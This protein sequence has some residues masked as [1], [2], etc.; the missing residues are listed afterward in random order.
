[1][2]DVLTN[3]FQFV[4]F[5]KPK[6]EKKVYAWNSTLPIKSN[7]KRKKIKLPKEK[8]YSQL[9]KELDKLV[10]RYVLKKGN[11]T[12]VRC[13]KVYSEGQKGLTCS[14]YWKRQYKGTRFDVDNLDPL[15]WR[16]CHSQIWESDK[17]GEYKDYMIK[18]LGEEGFKRLE[19]KARTITKFTKQDLKFMIDNFDKIYK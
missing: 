15:C 10:S 16:P 11:Y 7:R 12:C 18:K 1:M 5:P 6:K 3:T 4:S 17:Q 8:T 9:V 14:H 2:S 19:I 13:G